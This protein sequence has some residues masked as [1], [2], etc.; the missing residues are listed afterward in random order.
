MR[1]VLKRECDELEKLSEGKDVDWDAVKAAVAAAFSGTVHV[2]LGFGP[3]RD[4]RYKFNAENYLPFDWV[5]IDEVSMLPSSMMYRLVE[6]LDPSTDLLLVGDPDQLASVDAGSV[7]GDIAK[8]ATQKGSVLFPQT[9]VMRKQWRLPPEIDGLAR[10]LRL[11]T[12][13]DGQTLGNPKHVD[14]VIEYLH[15]NK[16][17]ISWINPDTDKDA[18]IDVRK[19]V[20]DHARQLHAAA[21]SSDPQA[22]LNKRQELQLL[23]AHRE[24]K[25][26][27]SYWN[28]FVEHELGAY[29]DLRWYFGRPVMVTRNNRSVDLYN[30]DVGIIVPDADGQPVGAFSKGETFRLVP[31]MRLE[32]VE[33]VHALTIHKSQGSEYDE[34]IV[35]LPNESSRILTRE[36]FYTGI[37]RTKNRLTII[38]SE[39]VLRRAVSQAILRSSGLAARL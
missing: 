16:N 30:G 34:V 13:L 18:L 2:L 11:E 7:L 28:G 36:L 4:T 17:V 9:K 39:A 19:K 29:T 8:V 26:G 14:A 23:C 31:T 6:A 21:T 15:V 5:V 24:G 38:G 37:T 25:T 1:D 27:V 32:D 12:P 3:S 33:S 35:V 22:A 10:L 20:V